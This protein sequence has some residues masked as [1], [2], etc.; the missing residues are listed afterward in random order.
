M[1]NL[2]VFWMGMFLAMT[3]YA[4]Y[5]DSVVITVKHSLGLSHRASL[6]KVLEQIELLR[7]MMR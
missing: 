1:T 3:G 5:L 7:R 6:D 4:L 2:E